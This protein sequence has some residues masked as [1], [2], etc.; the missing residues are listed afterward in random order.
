MLTAEETELLRQIFTNDEI[1][2]LNQGKQLNFNKSRL[3]QAQLLL[4]A[5][6][7]T[8]NPNLGHL[9]FENQKIDEA[10]AQVLAGVIRKNTNITQLYLNHC[11]LSD[12]AGAILLSAIN[13]HPKLWLVSATGNALGSQSMQA[14][15]NSLQQSQAALKRLHL[16]NNHFDSQAT[17]YLGTI[18][19]AYANTLEQI[20][21]SNNSF[22][23]IS[24]ISS[25]AT[26]ITHCTALQSFNFEEL[27]LPASGVAVLLNSLRTAARCNTFHTITLK[28]QDLSLAANLEALIELLNSKPSNFWCLLLDRCRLGDQ[29][30]VRLIEGMKDKLKQGLSGHLSLSENGITGNGLLAFAGMQPRIH[31]LDLSAN[32]IAM[33]PN[34]FTS[35]FS[36]AGTLVIL[37]ISDN[38]LIDQA[39][40]QLARIIQNSPSLHN[41]LLAN[42]RLNGPGTKA[43]LQSLSSLT[44]LAILKLD[45][46][47]LT[48]DLI[49]DMVCAL[50][51]T[52]SDEFFNQTAQVLTQSLQPAAAK[53]L[54]NVLADSLENKLHRVVELLTT[55]GVTELAQAIA[56]LL[57]S[58]K[59]VVHKSKLIE[60]LKNTQAEHAYTH[61]SKFFKGL[62]HSR[63]PIESLKANKEKIMDKITAL[64]KITGILE[65]TIIE[66]I[67]KAETRTINLAGK[68]LNE[69]QVEAVLTLLIDAQS[70]IEHLNLN[71]NALGE[72]GV[73][74]LLAGLNSWTK[75]QTLEVCETQLT[76]NHLNNIISQLPSSIKTLNLSYNELNDTV[77]EGLA[78]Y[79]AK[80]HRL[81]NL[82]LAN[83]RTN[84]SIGPIGGE[85]LA[86]ALKNVALQRIH[87]SAHP[88]GDR[89]IS[90]M[91]DSLSQNPN[92]LK[93]LALW[94]CAINEPSTANKLLQLIESQQQSLQTINLGGVKLGDQKGEFAQALQKC[95]GL[96]ALSLW[97][98]GFDDDAIK[99]LVEGHQLAQLTGL[100]LGNNELTDAAITAL[101]ELISANPN[102]QKFAVYNNSMTDLGLASLIE[103][104]PAAIQE[105]NL[106]HTQVGDWTWANLTKRFT[107]GHFQRLTGLYVPDAKLNDFSDSLKA[108]LGSHQQAHNNFQLRTEMG[109]VV[110]VNDFMELSSKPIKDTVLSNE[111]SLEQQPPAVMPQVISTSQ[112]AIE[113]KSDLTTTQADKIDTGWYEQVDIH[114][115]LT[116]YLAHQPEVEL[117]APEYANHI[118]NASLLINQLLAYQ[119]QAEQRPVLMPLNLNENHW[120]LLS[121]RPGVNH[122]PTEIRY[123]DPMG[124]AMHP[125]VQQALTIVYP[126]IALQVSTPVL[127]QDGYNCG[128]WVVEIARSLVTTG[129]LPL[130]LD[131]Q[132]ARLQHQQ[133][134]QHIR[135]VASSASPTTQVNEPVTAPE[136]SSDSTFTAPQAQPEISASPAIEP[137]SPN[138][139]PVPATSVPVSPASAIPEEYVCPLTQQILYEP[140]GLSD[141]CSYERERIEMWLQ[142]NHISPMTG[143]PLTDTT[144]QFQ[145]TF[146]KLIRKYLAANPGLLDQV[147]LPQQLKLQ[148]KDA[149][150]THNLLKIEQLL[151]AEPRLLT[152]DLTSVGYATALHLAC[153]YGPVSVLQAILTRLGE[154]FKNVA[155]DG[156]NLLEQT[157]Y[158]L[159]IEGAKL[160]AECLGWSTAEYNQR[161]QTALAQQDI[162]RARLYLQLGADVNQVDSVGRSLLHQAVL[163]LQ[164]E[165]VNLLLEQGAA[166]NQADNMGNTPL[167]LAASHGLSPALQTIITQLI[168]HGAQHKTPNQANQTPKALAEAQGHSAVGQFI[169]F[170]HGVKKHGGWIQQLLQQQLAATVQ[171][172]QVPA[173]TGLAQAL[174]QQGLYAVPPQPAT[175]SQA[176]VAESATATPKPH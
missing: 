13:A 143:E 45:G 74:K 86:N 126:T 53:Q 20:D 131:I 41:L 138:I 90:Q 153:E 65:T 150:V 16:S 49:S 104:L 71:H 98:T 165:Q 31:T 169:H 174:S 84:S 106:I 80:N 99:V 19:K 61:L 173:N 142:D 11:E 75:L 73:T 124:Q 67:Q 166:V 66:K 94:G 163:N 18:I 87:L 6:A 51:P 158:R 64:Q 175:A 151:N 17:Q 117:R 102:L 154:R 54:V 147:Y 127:Q 113:S 133:D 42:N 167:H 70:S 160:I 132:Q 120:V 101:E 168:E 141:G 122:Q 145:L 63:Q 7:Y 109:E 108:A 79:L 52:L 78:S 162:T 128:P 12:A 4:I 58:I 5:R 88:L 55:N 10:V 34:E 82:L 9:W 57:V 103:H 135:Q 93:L 161:L 35:V 33:I 36:A 89:A 134:L 111:F 30:L 72:L 69:E 121:I 40:L 47:Q 60:L 68:K 48:D 83:N 146:Q 170:W 100:D 139:N 118:G 172:M 137:S 2:T 32:H 24:D 110:S 152:A 26:A 96:K 130:S 91:A 22:S 114:E 148:L 176:P 37:N 144:L 105:L 62:K 171:A 159:G 119:G 92:Q 8:T 39:G 77:A 3:N 1:E 164:P 23:D 115:L 81:E 112:S 157:G 129:Q 97:G 43:M 28:G 125:H 116:Y 50:T 44:A 107:H 56:E 136:T 14:L 15:A 123:V 21:I 155:P 85:Q 38:Q 140:V 27:H 76:A 29:G 25:L 149:F 46:N 156:Q 59:H 95:S